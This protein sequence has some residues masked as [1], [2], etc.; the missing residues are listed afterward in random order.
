[1]N[2]RGGFERF[3]AWIAELVFKLPLDGDLGD[4]RAF[5]LPERIGVLT[6]RSMTPHREED[7][8]QVDDGA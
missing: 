2:L 4:I 8:G 7:G 5:S 6:M 3:T 1:L